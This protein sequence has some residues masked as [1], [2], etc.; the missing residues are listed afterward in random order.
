MI[1]RIG[2]IAGSG[3]FPVLAAANARKDN[4]VVIAIGHEGETNN[5]LKENSDVFE[6]VKLGQLGKIIRILKANKVNRV[7]FAGAI[8][9]PK[10]LSGHAWPDARGLAML[11]KTRSV[12]DDVILRAIAKELEGE[13]IA[14][15]AATDLLRDCVPNAGVLTKRSLT[16]D[17]K[18]NAKIGWTAAKLIGQ[19]DVG[20]TVVVSQGLVVAVEAVEGT[21]ATIARAGELTKGRGGVVV[22]TCKPQQDERL[23]LPTIGVGTIEVIK[24]AGLTALVIE[25]RKTLILDPFAVINSANSYNISIESLVL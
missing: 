12:R 3:Q 13:G 7:A 11:A 10:I 9:R 1:D 25:A 6:T 2:I 24:K 4:K 19:A 14:V 20:Q 8:S 5:E 17:E 15:F 18:E 16:E 22:K 23:D 21:D